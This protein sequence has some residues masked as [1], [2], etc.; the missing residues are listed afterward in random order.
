MVSSPVQVDN[1]IRFGEV[2]AFARVRET[3]LLIRTNA[4][5]QRLLE[6]QEI[7]GFTG[8]GYRFALETTLQ[9]LP[10]P[11]QP[12]SVEFS[13]EAQRELDG[14]VSARGRFVFESGQ[15]AEIVLTA[16]T[17][18][19][20]SVE[21]TELEFGTIITGLTEERSVTIRNLLSR[22]VP[23]YA[24][25]DGGRAAVD[26]VEGV[27][28]FE[29]DAAVEG[30][31][32]LASANP[33]APGASVEVPFIFFADSATPN[34]DLATWRVGPCPSLDDCGTTIT[35]RGEPLRAPIVCTGPGVVDG[36]VDVGILNPPD[37]F[38][39]VLN[40]EAQTPIRLDSVIPPGFDT[41]FSIFTETVTPRT[42]AQGDSFDIELS[43][44]P[45]DLPP[46]DDA[47]NADIELRIANVVSMTE[48]APVRIP[49]AGGHGFPVLSTSADLLEY[50]SVRSGDQKVL[51]LRIR[52]D[53]PV[54]FEGLAELPNGSDYSVEVPLLE[55]EPG[56]VQEIEV[57]FAPT[58]NGE[59]SET[60]RIAN[61]DE[62]LDQAELVVDLEVQLRGTGVDLPAC[63]LALSAAA[64]DFG[65]IIR[66]QEARSVLALENSSGEDCIINGIELSLDTAPEFFLVS[67]S[68][69]AFEARLAPGEAL[70]IELGV[71]SDR[72][73]DDAGQDL[74]GS[75]S[76]YTSSTF[77]SRSFE[78]RANQRLQPVVAQPNF[79]DL[80]NGTDQCPS[81]E[82]PVDLLNGSD[83]NVTVTGASL[84]GVDAD[85]FTLQVPTPPFD[86]ESLTS[87]RFDVAYLPNEADPGLPSSAEL[88]ITLGDAEM[89]PIIVP[90]VG[91]AADQ[92]VV[93]HF[94][95]VEPN[96]AVAFAVPAYRSFA[97]QQVDSLQNE[98]I[99]AFDEF[100][101]IFSDQGVDHR[102][103]WLTEP[104]LDPRV[105]PP[106]TPNQCFSSFSFSVPAD[107]FNHDGRCGLFANGSINQHLSNW[108]AVEPNETPSV[109]AA[110]AAQFAKGDRS[111]ETNRILRSVAASV[112]PLQRGWNAEVYDQADYRHFV[113]TQ[114]RDD[115]SSD[116]DPVFLADFIRAARGA[117][118]FQSVGASTLVGDQNLECGSIAGLTEATPRLR[119]F[120]DRMAGGL[121]YSL[122]SVS[123]VE[124]A[125]AIG[126]ESAGLR[127]RIRLSRRASTPSLRVFADGVEVPQGGLEVGWAYDPGLQ[128]LNLQAESLLT[129]GTEVEVQYTPACF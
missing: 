71:R 25:V 69:P 7:E 94:T 53:G 119:D 106:G 72:E 39:T 27:A 5:P 76:A 97:G 54:T 2:P 99:N 67:P 90:L 34:R 48:L 120:A 40:C 103:G 126:E 51:R 18:Q 102:F 117:P 91:R 113:L 20:L 84:A 9:N 73:V 17:A 13:F 116:V 129:P 52:N 11:A 107:I 24:Q 22:S 63:T 15:M 121:N 57:A 46:G 16:R 111:F 70:E 77:G 56:A 65:R 1:L 12:L 45:T 128:T 123:P 31:G 64:F 124:G 23:V 41:G 104:T 60:L 30:S 42:L 50:R 86:V 37:D 87:A 55:I 62:R 118:R 66:D 38:Q 32:I 68:D 81:Y 59:R 101:A 100:Y 93:E 28:R 36:A 105:P 29:V 6:F 21:P 26:P 83:V 49:L 96:A 79:A 75:I 19:A 3:T 125:A 114:I 98:W 4:E 89:N 95:Q 8:D 127:R 47:E 92:P 80:R 43:F 108:V 61:R 33:L 58:M 35:L 109:R 115:Q 85:H 78:L 10:L 14:Q 110:W 112:R 122:C 88:R 82:V 74:V 44:D